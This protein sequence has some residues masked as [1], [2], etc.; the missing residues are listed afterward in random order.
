MVHDALGTA[1]TW[2]TTY[3]NSIEMKGWYSVYWGLYRDSTR[4][5]GNS[6]KVRWHRTYWDRWRDGTYTTGNPIEL[7]DGAEQNG[8]AMEMVQDILGLRR[9]CNKTYRELCREVAPTHRELYRDGTGPTERFV[10]RWYKTDLELDR[11][12]A[13]PTDNAIAMKGWYKTYWGPYRD[14]TGPAGDSTGM[15][16]DLLGTRLRWY[17]TCWELQGCYRT[18]WEHSRDCT[19]AT[20]HFTEL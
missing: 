19:G 3:S 8:N 16:Q 4:P 7:R 12:G 14:G 10:W 15:V 9:I 6:I 1:Y 18:Y 13:G 20:G 5:T 2:Y 17:K 11:D